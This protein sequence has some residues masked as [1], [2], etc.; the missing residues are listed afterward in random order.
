MGPEDDAFH[1][2]TKWSMSLAQRT[3]NVSQ[4]PASWT[5]PNAGLNLNN[6]VTTETLNVGAT[7]IAVQHDGKVKRRKIRNK[8]ERDSG[9]ATARDMHV[10]RGHTLK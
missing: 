9:R 8:K 10:Q 1:G 5:Q 3:R 7:S 6:A 2:K 4:L